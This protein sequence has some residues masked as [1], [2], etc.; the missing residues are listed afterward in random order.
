MCISIVLLIFDTFL[1]LP[2][3]IKYIWSKKC[4]LGSVLYVLARYPALALFI[5]EIYSF[6]F[7][8]SLQVCQ[9]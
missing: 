5:I 7:V 3:E 2:S 1:I 6:L 9:C 4:R 8:T